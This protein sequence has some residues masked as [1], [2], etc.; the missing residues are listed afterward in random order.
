MCF[1]F[2]QERERRPKEGTG[3][4][5]RK[6]EPEGGTG[7]GREGKKKV[8]KLAYVIFLIKTVSESTFMQFKT[9]IT[10]Q[11]NNTRLLL[12]KWL[13]QSPRLSILDSTLSGL[14]NPRLLNNLSSYSPK[15]RDTFCHRDITK[16]SRNRVKWL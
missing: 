12:C 7:R 14:L 8:G 5:D 11:L 2:I 4:G 16:A 15:G 1:S 9:E 6:G 13:L 10:K 3:R